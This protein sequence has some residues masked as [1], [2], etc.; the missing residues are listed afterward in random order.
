MRL[1]L[2]SIILPLLAVSGQAWAVS[3]LGTLPAP[4]V[5]ISPASGPPGTNVTITISGIPD[6]SNETYPYA[7]LYIYLPFSQQFGVTPQSQCGG[8]DCFP[9]YTHDMAVNHDFA[10]RT[11]TFSLFSTGN[12]APVYL[13]GLENSVCDVSVNG[14]IAERYF[15]LCNTK[16]QPAGTYEI[17]IGWAEEN[18]PQ[19]STIVKTVAFT[20]TQGSPSPPAQ[21][22]D[23]G[24]SIIQAYQDG[25]I[26][27]A[28]F[29]NGLSALGWNSQEIREALGA[30]GRLPHQMGAP[31][32]QEMQQIQEGLQKAGAGANPVQAVQ[33]LKEK[34]QQAVSASRQ[35]TVQ[36]A[37]KVQLTAYRHE[38]QA[39]A[40]AVPQVLPAAGT[41][42]AQGGSFWTVVTIA[43]SAGAAAAVGAG[44]LAARRTHKITN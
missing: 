38:T 7:D 5:S 33:A 32:P 20:V 40:P 36:L 19:I 17:K 13:D 27:E 34:A 14:R 44:V 10:N 24:N 42:A 28:D 9:V 4:D 8:E 1:I 12:P 31:V 22:V 35:E 2:F 39:D 23:N 11:V 30:I 3:D 6:I 25:R 37:A 15:T 43:A 26:S 16:D 21:K 29:Y 18:A 41:T